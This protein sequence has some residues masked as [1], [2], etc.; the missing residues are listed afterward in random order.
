MAVIERAGLDLPQLIA[1]NP[2]LSRYARNI[3]IVPQRIVN[4]ISSTAMR[5]LIRKQESIRF[6]TPD[7]VIDYIYQHALYGHDPAASTSPLSRATSELS[8]TCRLSE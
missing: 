7:A 2:T 8:A 3:D 1:S 6:L 5:T 4:T